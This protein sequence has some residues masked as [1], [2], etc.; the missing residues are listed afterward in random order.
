MIPKKIHYCWFGRGQM[1]ELAVKCIKSWEK[2]LPDYEIVM[3][4]EDNFDVNQNRY[5][6]EAYDAKKYAFVTDYVRLYALY[7]HG[8]IYMDTDVEVIKPLDDFL[9][10]RAFTG[11]EDNMM[12]VTGTMASEK[13]HKWV[14]ELLLG[15]T[16][17][18]FILSNG[19]FDN[20]PN[21]KVITDTTIKNYGWQSKNTY[22]V[23][24]EDLN[25]YPYDVFCAKEWRTQKLCVTENTHTIHHFSA[26]WHTKGQKLKRRISILLGHKITYFILSLINK[27]KGV[28]K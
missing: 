12:C 27:S 9:N 17:R 28:I 6:K 10:H 14:E 25:I 24:K 21:T 13:G 16:D 11:C 7:H 5:T 22:Q 2:Y 26:S 4:N 20:T 8:G 15:Y 18:V 19:S 1:P 23:L 3:W